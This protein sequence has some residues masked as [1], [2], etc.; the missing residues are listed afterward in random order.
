MGF[1]IKSREIYIDILRFLGLSLII[2]AHVSPPELLFQLRAFD[3]PLMLFVSGLAYSG[4]SP[5][6]SF[7]FFINR[8]KRL[9]VPVYIFLTA[10]F[11]IVYIAYLCGFD[12][13][14]RLN[15]AI[16]SYLLMEGIGYVWIIRVFLIVGL[17]TPFL[18]ALNNR[19]TGN[20]VILLLIAAV[21]AATELLIG[22]GVGMGNPVIK[23]IIYYGIGYGLIFLLGV[24]Y[25]RLSKLTKGCVFAIVAIAYGALQLYDNS[26]TG[27]IMSVNSYK[28]PPQALYLLYG[29]AM[30][31]IAVWVAKYFSRKVRIPKWIL[32]IGQNTIWIYLYHIPLV[33][34]TGLTGLSWF[35]RYA[36]VY[37]LATLIVLLQNLIVFR[38]K[39]KHHKYFVG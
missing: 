20:T 35:R 28:Y 7:K 23:S 3:V 19:I 24:R 32:F 11:I 13:G 22:N 18:L 1:E 14:I 30:A 21:L 34:L 15:Q 36:I 5:D 2:L 31:F 33:Q 27:G 10:Y 4:K 37:A 26:K 16:G 38:F 8:F 29:A 17:L 25:S 6:F 12:F 39:F 9:V